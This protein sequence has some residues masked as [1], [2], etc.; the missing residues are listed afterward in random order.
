MTMKQYERVCPICGKQFTTNSHTVKMCSPECVKIR[1]IQWNREYMLKDST[2]RSRRNLARLKAKEV[3]CKICGKSIE[4]T[5]EYGNWHTKMHDNCVYI[6]I[7]RTLNTGGKISNKQMSR[8]YVRGYTVASFKDEF[9]EYILD[10]PI[11]NENELQQ[12]C[13]SYDDELPLELDTLA[14][15]AYRLINEGVKK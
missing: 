14:D 7:I 12:G 3:K 6:D 10:S 1:K 9:K 13:L 4:H 11:S 15:E 2:R 5:Y 8:L